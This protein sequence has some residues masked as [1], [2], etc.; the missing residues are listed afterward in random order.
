MGIDDEI[1]GTRCLGRPPP[2]SDSDPFCLAVEQALPG[3]RS[4]ARRLG[5]ANE[6]LWSMFPYLPQP[7]G[8]GKRLR[9]AL[10]PFGGVAVRVARCILAMAAGIWHNNKIGAPVTRSPVACDH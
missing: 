3:F 2:F 1:G 10:A 8:C 9:S 7:A 5:Y 6:H 4:E